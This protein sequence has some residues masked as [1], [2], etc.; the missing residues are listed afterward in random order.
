MQQRRR[1]YLYA[2]HLPNK[3]ELLVCAET[4]AREPM[5][6]FTTALVRHLKARGKTASGIVF[7][8]EFVT[9]G[10]FDLFF[11]GRGG[12]DLQDM[13]MSRMGSRLFLARVSNSVKRGTSA[14]GLFTAS[15][16]VT[17]SILSSD[18]GS[19]V[20]GFELKAAGAGTSETDSVSQGLERILEMLGQHGY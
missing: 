18:D 7:S 20:D 8:P 19:V 16:V 15:V 6:T 14:A 12:A 1:S 10:G 13:P 3:V 4:A 9:A 2:T 5:G 17:F 11:A